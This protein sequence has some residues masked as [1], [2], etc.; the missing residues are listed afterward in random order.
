MWWTR[1]E[2]AVS[3]LGPSHTLSLLEMSQPAHRNV[4]EPFGRLDDPAVCSA[5]TYFLSSPTTD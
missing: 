5:A 3:A 2:Y 4:V 1:M